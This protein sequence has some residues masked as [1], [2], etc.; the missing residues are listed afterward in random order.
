MIRGGGVRALLCGTLAALLCVGGC[1]GYQIGNKGLYPEKIHTV[2]VPVF[3]SN[4]YRRNLGEK[5][6]EAVIKEIEKKADMKVVNDPN[7]DSVLIG[8]IL[9]DSKTVL[10]PSLSGDAREVQATMFV[11]VSWV[12]RQGLALRQDQNIPL[13][14]DIA[15]VIG[16]ANIVPEVGQSYATAQQQ[17]ICRIA[18]QIVGMM[19][20]PW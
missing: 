1:A 5:L 15:D 13:P 6:T 9:S 4:S 2:Y 7:A 14:Q 11:Q 12:D 10:V 3:Q 19:E 20:K 18:Q 16:A 17:A 8:R